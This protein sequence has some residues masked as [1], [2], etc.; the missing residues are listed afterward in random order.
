MPANQQQPTMQQLKKRA[1][2]LAKLP[3]NQGWL[4]LSRVLELLHRRDRAEFQDLIHS[5]ALGRRT[6]FY[7]RKVGQLIR[8]AKLSTYQAEH[9]GWT[10]L[11]IVGDKLNGKNAARLLKLAEENNAQELKRLINEDRPKTKSHCVLLYFSTDQYRQFRRAVLRHG[12]SSAGRGLVGKEEAIVRI[13]R[14]G[15]E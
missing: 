11:Q 5:G 15:N 10:K 9:I 7:L 6:A 12:G 13:I 4:E 14:L 8:T 2:V 1:L 3:R